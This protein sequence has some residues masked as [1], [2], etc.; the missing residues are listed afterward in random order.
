MA[1][2]VR[3]APDSNATS[4]EPES[5]TR[6]ISHGLQVLWQWRD[7]YIIPNQPRHY[8]RPLDLLSFFPA[9]DRSGSLVDVMFG[10]QPDVAAAEAFSQGAKT[11]T[12]I[13][14][15]PGDHGSPRQL[16]RCDPRQVA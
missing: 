12:D 2:D 4:V 9:I 15:D 10:A 6:E 16:A 13:N 5:V 14:P 11:P 8:F 3:H 7:L 1:G